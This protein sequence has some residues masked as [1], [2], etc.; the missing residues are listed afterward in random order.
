MCMRSVV[1]P[2]DK[3]SV[4]AFESQDEVEIQWALVDT[5]LVCA[6]AD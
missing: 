5:V 6:A 1:K 2:T 4:E 3:R